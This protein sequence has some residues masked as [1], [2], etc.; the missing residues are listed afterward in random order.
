MYREIEITGEQAD[1]VL[2]LQASMDEL[3]AEIRAEAEAIREGLKDEIKEGEI[4]LRIDVDS[5]L[6]RVTLWLGDEKLIS[7][8]YEAELAELEMEDAG[9]QSVH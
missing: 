5:E 4:P 2:A 3:E 1:K 6:E 9:A 7:Q 8:A